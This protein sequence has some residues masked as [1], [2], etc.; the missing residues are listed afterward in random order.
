MGPVPAVYASECFPLSHREMGMGWSIFV[1]N[2]FS[3]ILSLT[4]PSMLKQ[5]GPTGAICFYGGLNMF[6]TVMVFLGLPETKQRTLEELDYV[7][8][9]PTSRHASYQCRT[10]LPWFI[11]RHLLWQRS[12]VLTPL[13]RLAEPGQDASLTQ[14]AKNAS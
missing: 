5:M 1:N 11:K 3:T 13:Y 14:L 7:F 10:W 8:A 6:A 4:F 2:F 12:A 9:V